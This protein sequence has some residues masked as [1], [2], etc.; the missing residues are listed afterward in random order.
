MT[1][2]L[3][4]QFDPF[5]EEPAKPI[6]AES[7]YGGF[8]PQ[9]RGKKK[10]PNKQ[11]MM[12]M[13]QQ[14][15]SGQMQQPPGGGQMPQ[16]PP[17]AD[18]PPQMPPMGGQMPQQQPQAQPQTGIAPPTMPQVPDLRGRDEGSGMDMAGAM[19]QGRASR[20]TPRPMASAAAQMQPPIAGGMPA[21][22]MPGMPPQMPGMPP[23]MAGGLPQQG[24]QQQQQQQPRPIWDFKSGRKKD[25]TG[26]R[27]RRDITA[28]EQ[29]GFL[30]SAGEWRTSDPLGGDRADVYQMAYGIHPE[31]VR[32]LSPIERPINYSF[33]ELQKRQQE[34]MQNMGQA[35]YHQPNEDPE[36]F[37]REPEIQGVPA[38]EPMAMDGVSD[39]LKSLA[40]QQYYEGGNNA[41]RIRKIKEML[42]KQQMMNQQH[43]G[44]A[45]GPQEGQG[46]GMPGM[47]PMM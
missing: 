16:M 38:V 28:D 19:Q 27:G 9:M 3:F 37:Y 42:A 34:H 36:M 43:H 44:G 41:E 24:A 10:D 25:V 31:K 45:G 5:S 32:G 46:G 21:P 22:P 2:V 29:Q 4:E 39:I 1:K 12:A 17:G 33:D 20:S 13:I 8:T 15:M 14:M 18:R 47:P 26:L 30:Q 11:Q 23:Q 7:L 35:G 6:I 40:M